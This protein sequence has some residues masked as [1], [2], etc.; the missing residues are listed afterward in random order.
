VKLTATH[1]TGLVVGYSVL[2]VK[3]KY[4]SVKTHWAICCVERYYSAGIET[5]YRI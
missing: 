3:V 4:F 1:N 2:K 5:H